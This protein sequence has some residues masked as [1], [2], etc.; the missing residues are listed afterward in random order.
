MKKSFILLVLAS[1]FQSCAGFIDQMHR[2]FDRADGEYVNTPT[3]QGNFDMYRGN[4]KFQSNR[5]PPTSALLNQP[6]TSAQQPNVQ[7]AIRRQYESSARLVTRV[8]ADDLRDN[9]NNGSLWAAND[10]KTNHL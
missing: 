8:R 10:G 4:P 1:L 6:I 3:H 2:D 5:R 9:S 7:P